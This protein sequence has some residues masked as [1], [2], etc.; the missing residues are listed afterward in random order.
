[1]LT[2]RSTTGHGFPAL[3]QRWENQ[4]LLHWIASPAEIEPTLPEGLTVDPYYGAA[5]VAIGLLCIPDP[6]AD[7]RWQPPGASGIQLLTVRTY[8]RDRAGVPGIWFYSIDCNAVWNSLVTRFWFG[9]PFHAAEM[10]ATN[11]SALGF[12][13][14]RL[15]GGDWAHY[16]YQPI[17]P[18]REAPA[19]SLEFFLLERYCLYSRRTPASRL[20]RVQLRRLPCR[21]RQVDLNAWSLLPAKLAGLEMLR[22]R[23]DL[24]W[25]VNGLDVKV[26]RG[27]PAGFSL[28]GTN[29]FAE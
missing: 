11:G 1:L 16:R 4:L 23:P 13:S 27:I 24:A 19:A 6:R 22:C 18:E 15:G 12:C 25:A 8:V 26:Y 20:R 7:G 28:D 9:F 14:R 5:Y 2:A 10:T 21:F 3:R 17:G 29:G